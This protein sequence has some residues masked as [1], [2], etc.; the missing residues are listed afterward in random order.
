LRARKASPFEF[1]DDAVGVYHQCLHR[2][3]VYHSSFL[4]QGNERRILEG[5]LT[6][7]VRLDVRRVRRWAVGW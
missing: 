1:L 3:S 6:D 4:R 2:W 7:F 5:E